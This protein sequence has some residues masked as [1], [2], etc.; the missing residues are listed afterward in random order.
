ML[1]SVYNLSKV[2]F[3]LLL[4]QP[5]LVFLGHST[6]QLTAWKGAMKIFSNL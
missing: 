5:R 6:V 4:L 1:Y 2:D 3:S